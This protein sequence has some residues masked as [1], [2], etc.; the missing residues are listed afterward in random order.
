MGSSPRSKAGNTGL[1]LGTQV[2]QNCSR[3]DVL[4]TSPSGKY[5]MQCLFDHRTFFLFFPFLECLLGLEYGEQALKGNADLISSS[6]LLLKN[7]T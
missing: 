6:I 3:N 4:G 2:S 7:S 1:I 5:S